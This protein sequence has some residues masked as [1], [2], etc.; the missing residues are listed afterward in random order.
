VG[1]LDTPPEGT[2]VLRF[3]GLF[4]LLALIAGAFGFGG[5]SGD[6]AEFLKTLFFVLVALA[7]LGCVLNRTREPPGPLDEESDLTVPYFPPG[8]GVSRPQRRK[9]K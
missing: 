4:L 5:L 7:V 2:A 9:R 8:H 6:V 3:P 1:W